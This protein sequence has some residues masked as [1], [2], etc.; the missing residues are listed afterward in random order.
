[1]NSSASACGRLSARGSPAASRPRR[2]ARA[3]P[4]TPPSD[5]PAPPRGA[6]ADWR[7]RAAARGRRA[8][9]AFSSANPLGADG[10]HSGSPSRFCA[11][12]TG[13]M[14]GGG[15]P[16]ARNAAMIHS[17]GRL[18]LLRGA[19]QASGARHQRLR[20]LLEIA[21]GVE[22]ALGEPLDQRGRRLVGDEMARELGGDV[23]GGRGM[24]RER[25]RAPRGPARRRLSG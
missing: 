10:R 11:C 14:S 12:I 18:S 6:R 17:P 25:R 5:R 7:R 8:R 15:T 20:H 22:E 16:V 23:L 9:C 3:S 2:A 21:V 1:M 19:S 4:R 13:P 24:A